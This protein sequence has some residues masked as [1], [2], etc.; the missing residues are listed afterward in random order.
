MDRLEEMLLAM[1]TPRVFRSCYNCKNRYGCGVVGELP[2]PMMLDAG[3][4][5]GFW[6]LQEQMFIPTETELAGTYANSG[7]GKAE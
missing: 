1:R 3:Q 4:Q 7:R 5:C 2:V 6:R